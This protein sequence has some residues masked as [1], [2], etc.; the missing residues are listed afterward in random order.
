MNKCCNLSPVAYDA[1]VTSVAVS[2]SGSISH[3]TPQE[4]ALDW[5]KEEVD[6]CEC[7]PDDCKIYE[8]YSLAVFYFTTSNQPEPWSKCGMPD[9]LDDPASIAAANAA[10][11]ITTTTIPPM[12]DIGLLDE[13]T[14][15]WL[16]PVDACTWAG[17]VCRQTSKYVDR[18]EFG[19]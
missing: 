14:N 17:I 8:R 9:D 19:K 11:D 6:Y 2:V 10:C 13:G 1:Y 16:T 5:L 3:G 4:Q 15:A 7:D 18:I 12:L